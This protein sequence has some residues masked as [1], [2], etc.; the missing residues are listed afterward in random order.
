MEF[1]FLVP[2]RQ[3]V[4]PSTRAKIGGKIAPPNKGKNS[5][6]GIGTNCFDYLEN[7]FCLSQF[8]HFETLDSLVHIFVLVS[9]ISK[10]SHLP[11]GSFSSRYVIHYIKCYSLHWRFFLS[12]SHSLSFAVFAPSLFAYS[13]FWPIGIEPKVSPI[14]GIYFWGVRLDH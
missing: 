1:F 13:T 10:N 14:I 2:N 8:F 7:N 12:F 6:F 3:S 11:H 5:Y 9:S 4:N